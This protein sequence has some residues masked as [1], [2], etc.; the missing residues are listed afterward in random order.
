[1]QLRIQSSISGLPYSVRESII[2]TRNKTPETIRKEIDTAR[3]YLNYIEE[4][5]RVITPSTQA[6]D[7]EV[8]QLK[9][10]QKKSMTFFTALKT[11]HPEVYTE[12]KALAGLS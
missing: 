10:F 11:K 3:D 12:V 2:V 4:T 9:D 7:D 6:L 5:M 8:K 1:M